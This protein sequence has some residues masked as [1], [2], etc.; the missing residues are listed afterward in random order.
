MCNRPVWVVL[1]SVASDH[2]RSDTDPCKITSDQRGG[3]P[4][5][6][7]GAWEDYRGCWKGLGQSRKPPWRRAASL[8]PT[9]ARLQPGARVWR[10]L[11]CTNCPLQLSSV[12]PSS[13]EAK[14]HSEVKFQIRLFGIPTRCN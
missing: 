1:D 11:F 14:M 6:E 13:I 10:L 5:A 12:S 4:R 7:L 2:R 9:S 8:P 3:R